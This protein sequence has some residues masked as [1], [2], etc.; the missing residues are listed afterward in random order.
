MYLHCLSHDAG[1]RDDR[2][3][4]P[5][6]G[7]A[8]LVYDHALEPVHHIFADDTGCD[9]LVRPL[10]DQIEQTFQPF[11]LLFQLRDLLVLQLQ[12][13]DLLLQLFVL[14]LHV[15]QVDVVFEH[16]ADGM[17]GGFQDLQHGSDAVGEIVLCP[18]VSSLKDGYVGE[19]KEREH[20]EQ[21]SRYDDEGTFQL[22]LGL[23]APS[24]AK[25]P[26]HPL[27]GRPLLNSLRSIGWHTG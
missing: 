17:R 2:H 16:E 24:S 6:A 1:G 27:A 19:E 26:G 23:S 5:Y 4:L 11:V 7:A 12:R 20:E 9:Q 25:P 8:P 21:D 3:L 13:L 10:L 15:D 22:L 14:S 18:A